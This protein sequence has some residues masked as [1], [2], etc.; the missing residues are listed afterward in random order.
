MCENGAQQPRVHRCTSTFL[1]IRSTPTDGEQNSQMKIWMPETVNA[2]F[3][4]PVVLN[5]NRNLMEENSYDRSSSDG[6]EPSLPTSDLSNYQNFLQMREE[7]GQHAESLCTSGFTLESV[8]L[9]CTLKVFRNK[10][11]LAG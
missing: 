7:D 10:I 11:S 6:A 1:K 2:K 3:Q 4:A 5:R 9:C 8:K